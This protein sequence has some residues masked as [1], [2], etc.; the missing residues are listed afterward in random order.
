MDEFETRTFWDAEAN[1]FDAEVDH[2]LTTPEARSAWWELMRDLLPPAPARV[3]DLGCGTGSLSVLM[4]EHGYDVVG[5][6]L[7]PAMIQL[8][9]RKAEAHGLVIDFETGDASQRE[10]RDGTFDVVLARHVVWALPDPSSALVAWLRLLQ[11]NGRLVLVEGRWATDAGLTAA[12]LTALVEPVARVV[13]LRHLT[14]ASLW[15]HEITD[16]RYAVV[17]QR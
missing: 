11:P 13:E 3:A 8:A 15:G 5:R 16:E 1:D 14:N 9:K 6:D 10:V 12:E 4:A 17:A 7:S 2:G